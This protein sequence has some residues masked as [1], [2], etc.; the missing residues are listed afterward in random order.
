MDTWNEIGHDQSFHSVFTSDPLGYTAVHPAHITSAGRSRLM[1]ATDPTLLDSSHVLVKTVG[2]VLLITLN[3][4][5]ALN[6]INR[7]MAVKIFSILQVSDLASCHETFTVQDFHPS[8][9]A[10]QNVIEWIIWLPLNSFWSPICE[11]ESGENACWCADVSMGSDQCYWVHRSSH[12]YL[13]SNPRLPPFLPSSPPASLPSCIP[14]SCLPPLL[15]P[16]FLPPLLP[17]FR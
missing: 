10:E 4:P 7:S 3:R 5:S 2:S 13:S 17:S 15:P 1:S 6:A 8:I 14:L 16:S 9:E 12:A 11:C